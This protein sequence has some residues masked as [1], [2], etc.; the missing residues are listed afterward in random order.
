LAW[1]QA[2]EAPGEHAALDTGGHWKHEAYHYVRGRP[3][4]AAGQIPPKLYATK[5]SS[6]PGQKNHGKS[7]LLDLNQR[8][9]VIKNRLR[10]YLIS[11]DTVKD[12]FFNRL[13]ITVPE[14]G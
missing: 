5:G 3:P 14:P 7:S 2:V 11:T 6:T 4:A 8:D 9:K 13:R 12:L 10:L 1:D